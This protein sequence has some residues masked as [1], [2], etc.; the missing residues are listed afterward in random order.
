MVLPT[1]IQQRGDRNFLVIRLHLT[2]VTVSLFSFISG[3]HIVE[4]VILHSSF[5]VCVCVK[6]VQHLL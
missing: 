3:A 5:F 4:N 1:E 2:A 6:V